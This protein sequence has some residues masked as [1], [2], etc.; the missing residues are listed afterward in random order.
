[1]PQANISQV[2]SQLFGFF[3]FMSVYSKVFINVAHHAQVPPLLFAPPEGLMAQHSPF[4][5]R[6]GTNVCQSAQRVLSERFPA[7]DR[8]LVTFVARHGETV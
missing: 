6:G 1:M 3:L 7:L 2:S 8:E 4:F 5:P